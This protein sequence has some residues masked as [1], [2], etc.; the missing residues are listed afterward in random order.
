MTSEG[1]GSIFQKGTFRS[2]SG[3][4]LTGKIECDNL[5]IDDLECLCSWIV[6]KWGAEWC[7]VYG[8]PTGGSALAEVFLST[9]FV[10]NPDMPVLILDDVY[11]TGAS[12]A[13]ARSKFGHQETMAVV[14]FARSGI[15]LDRVHTLFQA[16]LPV[17]RKG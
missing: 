2:H 5:T 11:T 17:G 16:N 9:F 7:G 4:T 13:E 14:I 3:L 12:I 10:Y 8:I 1:R 6:E 15:I